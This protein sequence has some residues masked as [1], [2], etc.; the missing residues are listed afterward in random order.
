MTRFA[1]RTLAA[2]PA[3]TKTV[4]GGI[5]AMTT[6]AGALVLVTSLIPVFAVCMAALGARDAGREL[7]RFRIGARGGG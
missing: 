6:V 1:W 4:V 2:L 7:S 5:D 3:A